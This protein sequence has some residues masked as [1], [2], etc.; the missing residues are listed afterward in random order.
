MEPIAHI[1][2]PFPQKF[3]IPRQS[4]LA[5]TRACIYFEPQYA[6]AD[7]VKGLDGFSHIWL[8]WEFQDIASEW[9]P[10]VR[11]PLLGGNKHMGVFATRSPFRPNPIGLSS[12]ELE[13]IEYTDEGPVLHVR[14]ADLRNGTP[15]YDIKP[16]LAYTDSHPEATGGFT[17]EVAWQ[18]L[19]V[20]IDDAA[21]D[22]FE[23]LPTETQRELVQVLEQ[24]PRP[25]RQRGATKDFAITYAHCNVAFCVEDGIATVTRIEHTH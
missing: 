18:T 12:V 3:G 16:Y 21:C 1:R 2:T 25:A 13:R 24:D 7:A 17:D 14:G 6:N 20:K 8:I 22:A 15:I 5:E 11:P 9:S 23:A 10:T 4:G 19:A